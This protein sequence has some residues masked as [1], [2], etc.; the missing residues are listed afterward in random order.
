MAPFTCTALRQDAEN[1]DGDA[2]MWRSSESLVDFGDFA[3][4]YR[5]M[6]ESHGI[7]LGWM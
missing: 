1:S 2:E 3:G 6:I 5:I 4:F 7:S